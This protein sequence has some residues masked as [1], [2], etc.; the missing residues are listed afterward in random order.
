MA[1]NFNQ[2]I[3]EATTVEEMASALV[4]WAVGMSETSTLS[5]QEWL[6]KLQSLTTGAGSIVDS[7]VA[8]GG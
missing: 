8:S 1:T 7:E 6:A 2:A 4:V 5:P 3:R